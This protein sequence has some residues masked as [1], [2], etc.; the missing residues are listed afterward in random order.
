MTE[1]LAAATPETTITPEP[2]AAVEP[3]GP[4]RLGNY[5]GN[6]DVL[7]IHDIERDKWV[8]MPPRSPIST[9]DELLTLPKFRTH[10]VLAD[11]NAHLSGGTRVHLPVEKL[12]TLATDTQLNLENDLRPPAAQRGP[13]RQPDCHAGRRPTA[14][15]P[16]GRLGESGG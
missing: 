15:I 1:D 16:T 10:V 5:L 8:R 6:N 12:D 13:E 2:P 4:Q 7:L 9:G 14:R 11:I 3:T